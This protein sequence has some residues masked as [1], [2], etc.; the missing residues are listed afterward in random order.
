MVFDFAK[1]L[2]KNVFFW[3]RAKNKTIPKLD[4]LVQCLRLSF[5]GT[6]LSTIYELSIP[7]FAARWFVRSC[8]LIFPGADHWKVY[9]SGENCIKTLYPYLKNYT[10]VSNSIIKCI[11]PLNALPCCKLLSNESRS[12]EWMLCFCATIAAQITK[13]TTSCGIEQL[14]LLQK[15]WESERLRKD[16]MHGNIT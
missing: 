5:F 14:Q 6:D 1:F 15:G 9:W 8:R 11:W 3:Y 7:N 2:E 4:F 13:E 16:Q 10:P 12:N